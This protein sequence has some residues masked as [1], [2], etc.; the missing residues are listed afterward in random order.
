MPSYY[1]IQDLVAD[2]DIEE[3]FAFAS[4]YRGAEEMVYIRAIMLAKEKGNFELA[5]KIVSDPRVTPS[6]QRVMLARLNEDEARASLN[7]ERLQE[8][9]KYSQFI[10]SGQGL[11][12]HF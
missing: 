1:E 12:S 7:E 10:S 2:G 4:Q 9:L 11:G 3:I 6:A 5:R 8:E